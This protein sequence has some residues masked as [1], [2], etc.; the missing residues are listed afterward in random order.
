VMHGACLEHDCR[1][2]KPGAARMSRSFTC[3]RQP[4]V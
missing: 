2:R 4:G 3:K 1:E